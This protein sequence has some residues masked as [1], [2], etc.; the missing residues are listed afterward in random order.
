MGSIFCR[1]TLLHVLAQEIGTQRSSAL[2]PRPCPKYGGSYDVPGGLWDLATVTEPDQ[3]GTRGSLAFL[4]SQ[5]VGRF[6]AAFLTKARKCRTTAEGSPRREAR[7]RGC[8]T[9]AAPL[10]RRYT[11]PSIFIRRTDSGTME[12][13][14]PAATKL[15]ADVMRGTCWP[16]RGLN[17][18]AWQAAVCRDHC[19]AGHERATCHPW[20]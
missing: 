20:L 1:R 14:S 16:M 17:P 11:T 12:I 6:I 2:P 13:P 7:F 5:K 10:S 9:R 3:R 4:V 19:T 8:V 18:A 15:S